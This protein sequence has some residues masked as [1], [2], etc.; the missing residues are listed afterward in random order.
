MSCNAFK[1]VFLIGLLTASAG[2]SGQ[3]VAQGGALVATPHGPRQWYVQLD[4]R[5][6]FRSALKVTNEG[7][8]PSK[9][10]LTWNGGLFYRQS[11]IV[12]EIAKLPDEYVG[13]PLH[14]KAFRYVRD[15]RAWWENFA[16]GNWHHHPV[17]NLNG[18][19]SN[20]CG[21]DSR[22]FALL[23]HNMGYQTR[24]TWY[25]HHGVAG[26]MVDGQWGMYD[27]TYGVYYMDEHG[28]VVDENY[29]ATDSTPILEPTHKMAGFNFSDTTHTDY[30]HSP[31]NAKVLQERRSVGQAPV[32]NSP[33][34]PPID[35]EMKFTLPAE[36]SLTLPVALSRE[37]PTREDGYPVLGSA[38][39]FAGAKI[40]V[41]AGTL[42][43]VDAPLVL[44]SVEG[45]GRFKLHGR[46]Y[47][48]EGLNAHLS[49]F[50]TFNHAVQIEESQSSLVFSYSLNPKILSFGRSNE[51]VLRGV[52]G[53]IISSL[54]SEA[55]QLDTQDQVPTGELKVLTSENEAFSVDGANW[56]PSGTVL[57]L[58]SRG[59]RW[60]AYMVQF[61]SANDAS[62]S[63]DQSAHVVP[64]K[65]TSVFSSRITEVQSER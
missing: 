56:Y 36:G 19:G 9:F 37:V 13:E 16:T 20:V 57:H 55:V 3:E 44:I 26:V 31:S 64:G 53:A 40:A 6:P 1:A 48:T 12:A 27:V 34:P 29:L 46:E 35:E 5:A 33:I 49:L 50:D 25:P 42:G 8:G 60:D 4:T 62:A 23:L 39:I 47:D 14:L 7:A 22:V 28:R 58:P 17:V 18:L 54:L 30:A 61:R 52:D 10:E 24:T 32:F 63:E 51:I 2:V 15:R 43:E 38:P 41:P 45:N 11:Q 65:H 59:T 21:T